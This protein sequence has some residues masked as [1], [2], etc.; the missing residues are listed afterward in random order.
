LSSSKIYLKRHV[1]GKNYFAVENIHV[2]AE[3]ELVNHFAVGTICVVYN[4]HLF[5]KPGF[6]SL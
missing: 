3:G 5:A 6:S 1:D 2:M 4:H